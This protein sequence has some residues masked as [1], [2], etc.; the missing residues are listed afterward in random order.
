MAEV[1][2]MPKLGFNM[3]EGELVKWH[4]QVGETVKKGEVLFEINTDKTTMP[5]EATADGT[6]LKI[7]LGEG[8]FADVFTP[9][10]VVGNPG[11][12]PDAAIAAA[13]GG[14]APAAAPAAA[15]EAPAAAAAPA[16]P[17]APAVDIK[18]LKLTPK[19]KKLIKDEGIDPASLAGIQGTG[20]Q[21]GITAKDI[22]A[23]P[24]AR[25]IAEQKGVDLSTVQGTGAAGKIMK[26]DVEAAAAAA[27]AAKPAAAAPAENPNLQVASVAPYKGVR[28]IIGE[29]LAHSKFTAPHLYFTDAVD[30]T[31]M[32]AFRKKL[33][34]TSEVKIAVS[35]LLTMAACK[36]LKKYPGINVTL[37]DEKI[38]TYKSINVGT[39]VAG[40]NGLVVPVIKN[41]Q[42]KTLTDVAKESKDLVAR[43]KEGKLAPEEYSE[44]TFS[45]SNLGMFGIGNFTAIINAPE[46]AILSV[47]SVRKTP[48]VVTDENG[49]DVIA[50]RP[51]MNIQLTVDHRLIDGLLASQFVEYM[52]E[53]LEDPIKILM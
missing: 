34:E 47:S 42:N 27:P 23:S 11:E 25:K 20:Y 49:E 52:K 18:D 14:A 29:K 7:M 43:A 10:A 33:N 35:D 4:K 17:A 5:V 28:K 2:I 48:V 9:I 21:G 53:L 12:D 36:A 45:I 1:I 32:T 16:A 6:V 13:A 41:V 19:A 39:A 15:E 40:D 8:E 37:Q 51:M 24:L 30:T 46:A 38:I 26:A 44:G 31:A 50:I 3:D 22:K